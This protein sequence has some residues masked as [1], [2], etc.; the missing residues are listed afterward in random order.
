MRSDT[1][2]P[3]VTRVKLEGETI[4]LHQVPENESKPYRL[5]IPTSPAQEPATC[6]LIE[7]LNLK[8]RLRST[9]AALAKLEKQHSDALTERDNALDEADR[10]RSL[11]HGTRK[12]KEEVD[13]KAFVIRLENDRL[14]AH[15]GT[16]IPEAT[17]LEL[18]S[19]PSLKFETYSS[20]S[21]S[22]SA[23]TSTSTLFSEDAFEL[24][25]MPK[26]VEL[27]VLLNG[28]R[29]QSSQLQSVNQDL[30]SDNVSLKHYLD[31]LQAAQTSYDSLLGAERAR[32]ECLSSSLEEEKKR[33]EE[34]RRTLTLSQTP[35]ESSRLETPILG[36][37]LLKAS[38][39]K[40]PVVAAPS[41]L[42]SPSLSPSPSPPPFPSPPVTP[43]RQRVPTRDL[44][45]SAE[46]VRMFNV[47]WAPILQG[48]PATTP[49]QDPQHDQVGAERTKGSTV[50]ESSQSLV[51]V[52]Q[53]PKA[54]KKG[55]RRG[56]PG[57]RGSETRQK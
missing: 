35:E 29:A 21:V 10:L 33:N 13:D 4:H 27:H 2:L 34:L 6:S 3:G 28:A 26:A 42:P 18:D 5:P 31:L 49:A 38:T 45:P 50:G 37:V 44:P 30:Q 11:L 57:W 12:I 40:P 19:V 7:H 56:P 41:P 47:A 15:L 24:S 55:K 43:R 32:S 8:Q 1:Y 39:A 25:S 14:R 9:T 20:K 22:A 17:K 54:G 36:D 53:S 52:V 23:S 48:L 51:D 46:Q 16:T